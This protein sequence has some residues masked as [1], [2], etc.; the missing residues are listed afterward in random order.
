MSHVPAPV[1][2]AA[3]LKACLFDL[4]GVIIDTA[5]YHYLAWKEIA[6]ELGFA[7]TEE[8]NERLKGVSRVRSLEIL[9]EVGGI[10]LDDATKAR[11]AEKKNGRYLEYVLKMAPEEILPGA[12]DFLVDCRRDGLKTGLVSASK[13]AATVLNHLQ[14]RALFDAIIDGNAVA[15]TKPAPDGFLACAHLIGVTPQCC[16]VF[17]DAEVGIEAARAAGMFSVGI[18]DAKRLNNANFVVSGLKVLSLDALRARWTAASDRR[19]SR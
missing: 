18:G 2:R 16:A 10:T 8:D 4:D 12:K 5:R 15:K 17:E 19:A 11:L 1:S 13:N 7:F 6:R 3:S 14:I 9:L